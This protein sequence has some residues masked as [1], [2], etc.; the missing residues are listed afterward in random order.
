[1]RIE[2][3]DGGLRVPATRPRALDAIYGEPWPGVPVIGVPADVAHLFAEAH[4]RLCGRPALAHLGD[5]LLVG[6]SH[7]RSPEVFGGDSPA[8]LDEL[9]ALVAAASNPVVLA[10]PGV[11]VDEAVP[12]LHALA[13]AGNL[14]VLNTWGAKGVFDWRSPHHLATVGLQERDFELAGLADA[15]LIIATGV[16]DREAVGWRLAPA[17]DVPP[18]SLGALAHRWGRPRSAI[19]VPALR[20]ALARVTQ[21]GWERDAVPLAPTRVTR[22]YAAAVGPDGLVAADPGIAGYWIARTFAT[23]RLGSVLVPADPTVHGFAIACAI[24]ARLLD[25]G[26]AVLAVVDVRHEVHDRLLDVAGGL[27]VAVSLEVWADEGE[28]IDA[29]AHQLRLDGLMATG[30]VATVATDMGQLDEMEAIAG[31]IVAWRESSTAF[32]DAC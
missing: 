25:P 23:T 17:V 19:E 7:R 14:G 6:P 3:R 30:G 28:N 5:G 9:L 12:G 4:V 24:V 10:G 32:A 2:R 26:R 27:G 1:M 13:A 11:V 31:P 15:D 16:D 21:A 20:A 29:G 22:H 18:A 8:S